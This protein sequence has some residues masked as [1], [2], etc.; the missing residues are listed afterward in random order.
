VLNRYILQQSVTSR[1]DVT[2]QQ[3]MPPESS[4]GASAPNAVI[5]RFPALGYRDFRLLWLGQIV[6]I[7]GS[8]MQNVAIGWEIYERTGSA[9]MLGLVGLARVVPIIV[10]SLLGGVVADSYNR[11]RIMMLSQ[12]VA[13]L[14]A[15]ALGTL[16]AL[17]LSSAAAILSLTAVTAASAA[18]DN[19]ARQS[20]VPNLVAPEHLTNAVSLNMMLF[21]TAMIAGPALAG[22]LIATVDVSIVY[23]INAATFLAVIAAL[24]A[25]RIRERPSP[26]RSHVTRG[27]FLEGLRFVRSNRTIWATM[28]LDFFATFFASATALIPVFAKEVLGVGAGGM[29]L[30]YSAEAVGSL[31]AGAVMSTLPDP[32]RKGTLLL[33]S[34]M[35]YG[36]ATALYGLSTNYVLSLGLL[37]LVGA[38]D[39]V[40]TVLRSTIR[41]KATPDYIRGR[42]TSVNMLFF[43]GGPQ[44]GNLEAGIVAGLIGAPLAVVTGGVATV[45]VVALMAWIYPTLRRFEA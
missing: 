13:M 12:S 27:A 28:L 8:Q 5:R 9:V 10:F 30:L 20:L 2:D 18:F 33:G 14:S 43:M 31:I 26:G 45:V 1:D 41:Q 32:R 38:G 39:S 34:V 16:S 35:L 23:W 24:A 36:A 6:S 3:P 29:G 15:I 19:P 37:A 44:L 7:S 25:M 40:S 42:M 4:A 22:V 17:D 21:H 11:R